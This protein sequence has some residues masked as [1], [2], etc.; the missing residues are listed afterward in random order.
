ML[1]M[2]SFCEK[3][4]KIEL[5]AH[6]NGS[7]SRNTLRQ[8]GCTDDAI[9]EYQ[10][11]QTTIEEVFKLFKVAHKATSTKKN[12]Y[13]ST[14]TVIKEFAEDN[15]IYLELRTTPRKELD[16]TEEEY[17][18][19]VI[20]AIIDKESPNI[21]VKLL[22]S[23]D[24]RRNHQEQSETLDAII[25]FKNM[26]PDI[27]RGVDLSGDPAQG[28]FYR[29]LFEKARRNG[30][31]CAIHCA[32]IKN[33]TEVIDILNFKPERLG[34]GTF[35][36]PNYTSNAEIWNLY[37]KLQIPVECCLSSNVICLTSKSHREHHVQEWMKNDLPYCLA[38]DDKGVF[39]TTLSKEFL[40][41][42]E[43]FNLN[44]KDLWKISDNAINYS[45]AL[46]EEKEMLHEKL[47]LWKIQ[48][49]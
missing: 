33:N 30:L 11:E 15:V 13:L 27:V 36:H 6:L 19:T 47:K 31:F 5:H 44:K 29:D 7:L 41:L 3:L 45:F 25:K 23:L 48:N 2:E 22:L 8:L 14:K 16:M 28:T 42:Q 21:I 9:L 38:T 18:Q 37:T 32:E 26:Y 12:L 39:N 35:L 34:H 49:M 40:H 20:N 17:I 46:S 10:S 43:S 1:E 24:R 4:P